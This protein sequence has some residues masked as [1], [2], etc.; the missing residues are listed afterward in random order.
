MSF[1]LRGAGQ[2]LPS[3]NALP[4]N[5]NGMQ[6]ETPNFPFPEASNNVTAHSSQ[7]TAH[8]SQ[9]TADS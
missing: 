4:A 8:S 5:H 2:A 1:Q 6:R 7:L 9:L 3:G